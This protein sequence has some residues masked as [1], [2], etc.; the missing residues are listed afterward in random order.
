MEAATEACLEGLFG[1]LDAGVEEGERDGD[2]CETVWGHGSDRKDG[3]CGGAMERTG[4]V[5][6]VPSM[7]RTVLVLAR[8]VLSPRTFLRPWH[9]GLVHYRLGSEPG[10]GN[11]G[12]PHTGARKGA[13]RGRGGG[14][15]VVAEPSS[16]PPLQVAIVAGNFELAEVIK[17]HKDS[18]IGEFCPFQVSAD[19][20]FVGVVRAHHGPCRYGDVLRE[21]PV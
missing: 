12:G 19:C 7:H 1:R 18:D 9:A 5:T 3:V 17:T 20:G 15:L 2:R 8:R 16:R 21:G 13:A 6:G 4:R 11:H 10:A 14:D